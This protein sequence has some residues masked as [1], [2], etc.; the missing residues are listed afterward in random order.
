MMTQM[1]IENTSVFRRRGGW[2]FAV[3]GA[4]LAGM[5][6]VFSIIHQVMAAARPTATS[7]NLA[8]DR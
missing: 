6:L 8:A 7:I 5:I 4:L 3:A 2:P 1:G